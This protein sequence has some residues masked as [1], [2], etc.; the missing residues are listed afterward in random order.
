MEGGVMVDSQRIEERFAQDIAEIKS[1]LKELAMVTV[2]L[3]LHNQRIDTIEN[4]V[5][6][7]ETDFE[8]AWANIQDVKMTCKLR[9]GVYEKG[10]KY[11]EEHG[12]NDT[13]DTWLN[14]LLGGAVRNGVWIA[15][16][17]LISTAI[18]ILVKR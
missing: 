10:L 11:F 18:S 2:T 17:A 7:V 16:A 6:R 5:A 3:A 4:R 1:T 13:P 8:Q 12:S 15:V 9:E 14:Q